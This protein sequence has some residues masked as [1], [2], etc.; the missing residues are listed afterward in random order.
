MALHRLSLFT[1]LLLLATLAL[2]PVRADVPKTPTGK[3]PLELLVHGF[4]APTGVAVDPDGTVFFTDRKEGRLWQRAS[5]GSLTILLERLEQP[6]GLVR[7]ED[8]TF[9]V[10]ADAFQEH[11]E[12]AW[13]KGV[14]LKRTPNDGSVSIVA[15]NFRKPKQL[16]FDRD[17]RL[18]LSTRGGLRSQED[19]AVEE[20]QVEPDDD[21]GTEDAPAADAEE[22]EET[23]EPPEAFRGTVS[24]I[25]AEDG[26][27]LASH[28]GFRR[29][30]GVVADEAGTLTVVAKG[31]KPKEPPLKGTLFQIEANGDANVLVEERFK[32][33]KGLVRDVLGQFFLAVKKDPETPKD[34]GLMLKVA[35][36]GT[37]TRFAQDFERPWGLTFDPQGNFYVTDPKAGR[38]YRFLAPAPP[39]LADHPA[40]TRE[41][42]VTLAGTTEPEARITVRGGQEEVTTFPNSEGRFSLDVPLLPDQVNQLKVYATGAKGEGLTSA[43]ALAP[44]QQQTTP[45]PPSIVLVVQITDPTPGATVTADSVLVRGLV[46]AGGLEVGVTVNSSPAAVVGNTFAAHV[47]VSPETTTLTAIATTV[48]GASATQS[49]V[50][51]VATAPTPA[52]TLRASPASGVAPLRVSFS[53]VGGPVPT[54]VE[55]DREGDGLIEFTGTSLEGQ[56]FTYAQAGV[57]TPSATITDSDGN[58]FT[59]GTVVQVYDRAGLD[60]VLQSKWTG[61]RGA[62]REGRIEEALEFIAQDFREEFRL[63]FTALAPFLPTLGQ[64]LEGIRFVA[65]RGHR[66]QYELLSTEDGVTFSY[67]VEFIRDVDGIWRIAFF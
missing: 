65:I 64:E 28:P 57:Y 30:S 20:Q 14:L 19:P 36:D 31:F 41:A 53:L 59:A 42:Q 16:A 45:P 5:N 46:D 67:N 27:I 54:A 24:R 34:G 38:I 23:E 37:F 50:V 40:T 26:Q 58:R 3:A 8:G 43:A 32:R 4:L 48:T 35:P 66:A 21:E 17:N 51:T 63:D 44:T 55:L 12:G 60:N 33:P 10:V 47:P 1:L 11:Q 18:L 61:M 9:Y 39:S 52:V 6:R 49:I 13:S 15:E 62:L 25:N 29:P 56:S 2:D 7:G 22:D